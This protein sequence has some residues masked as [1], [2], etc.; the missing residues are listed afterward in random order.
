M[1]GKIQ[2]VN[3]C[4]APVGAAGDSVDE[5]MISKKGKGKGNRI[6]PEILVSLDYHLP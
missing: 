3:R 1:G 6:D 4:A 5:G 2:T